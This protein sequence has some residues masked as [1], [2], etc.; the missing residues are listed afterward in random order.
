MCTCRSKK[1][2]AWTDTLVVRTHEVARRRSAK[3]SSVPQTS[4]SRSRGPRTTA[5]FVN[6][7]AARRASIDSYLSLTPL[8]SAS[9]NTISGASVPSMWRWSSAF[10]MPYASISFMT[11]HDFSRRVPRTHSCRG[12]ATMV[13][14]EHFG[15]T[16]A[17]GYIGGRLVPLLL[18]R[19]HDVTC[20]ARNPARLIGRIAGAGSSRATSFSAMTFCARCTVRTSRTTSY[21][22]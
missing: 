15:L 7:Y 18:E 9:A 8:R 11:Q 22:R 12:C 10:G 5:G 20:L 16:G 19:G 2:S 1:I 14:S 13:A 21:I 4:W 6:S 17:T 3:S